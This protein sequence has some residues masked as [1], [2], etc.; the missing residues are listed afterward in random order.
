MNT[1]FNDFG[2]VTYQ[3]GMPG[4]DEDIKNRYPQAIRTVNS[5]HKSHFHKSQAYAYLLVRQYLER[6]V[7]DKSDAKRILEILGLERYYLIGGI[8]C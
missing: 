8:N 7:E 3:I 4:S 6:M 1:C 2:V 5:Y